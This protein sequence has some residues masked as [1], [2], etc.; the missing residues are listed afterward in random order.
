MRMQLK[1]GAAGQ[2]GL[3]N[4]YYK[5]AFPRTPILGHF[6]NS[7]WTGGD[8]VSHASEKARRAPEDEGQRPF[9]VTIL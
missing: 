5:G 3:G 1:F 4:G 2:S 8:A 6:S 9:V 7:R